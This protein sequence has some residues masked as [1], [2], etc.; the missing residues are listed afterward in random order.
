MLQSAELEGFWWGKNSQLTHTQRSL[1]ML[2]S[3]QAKNDGA[4]ESVDFPPAEGQITE[5]NT[6]TKR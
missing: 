6:G 1:E 2:E 5:E 3:D 4:E